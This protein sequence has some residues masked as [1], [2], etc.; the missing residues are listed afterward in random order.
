MRT[1]IE[2]RL[3][4]LFMDAELAGVFDE[5]EEMLAEKE[6]AGEEVGGLWIWETFKALCQ[7]E[8]LV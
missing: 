4:D 8:E 2:A 3:D 5:M 7:R 1:D 6:E